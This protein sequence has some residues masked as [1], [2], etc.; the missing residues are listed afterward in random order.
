MDLRDEQ[1]SKHPK[2]VSS[3]ASS[4]QVGPKDLMFFP[5]CNSSSEE[6]P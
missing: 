2:Y 6:Q 1:P 5:M 4:L 3:S